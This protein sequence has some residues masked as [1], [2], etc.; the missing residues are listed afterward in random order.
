MI[1]RLLAI[2]IV[3]ASAL[4][5]VALSVL[6]GLQLGY[7]LALAALV[8]FVGFHTMTAAAR[9]RL[10]HTGLHSSTWEAGKRL[11]GLP[12]VFDHPGIERS[13][14]ARMLEEFERDEAYNRLGL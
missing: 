4:G 6:E 3:I 5:L 10:T 9:P 14:R 2:A 12:S 8:L 13:T 7:G 11:R 1:A